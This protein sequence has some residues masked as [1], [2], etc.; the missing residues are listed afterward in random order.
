MGDMGHTR[1]F[2]LDLLLPLKTRKHCRSWNA[3]PG[4]D[5]NIWS[6]IARSW[7]IIFDVVKVMLFNN[8]WHELDN[9]QPCFYIFLNSC[10]FCL[11]SKYSPKLS[12]SLN[13]KI[14]E[15]GDWSHIINYHI[16][17]T[18]KTYLTHIYNQLLFGWLVDLWYLSI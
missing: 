11:S 17:Y 15:K 4:W 2:Y 8:E 10:S 6:R 18:V 1:S 12:H 3:K 13:T 7:Q 9:W 16:K 5:V 14:K